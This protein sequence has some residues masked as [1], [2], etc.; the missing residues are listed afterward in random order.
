MADW[1]RARVT[2]AV[3]LQVES[4]IPDTGFKQRGTRFGLARR[5]HGPVV[6]ELRHRSVDCPAASTSKI[7]TIEV[8]REWPKRDAVG[9]GGAIQSN[10]APTPRGHSSR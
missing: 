8:S 10:S 5:Q 4:S 9:P 6:L 1:E 3:A 7:T 2:T